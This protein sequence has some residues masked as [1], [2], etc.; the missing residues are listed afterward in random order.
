MSNVANGVEIVIVFLN[1]CVIDHTSKISNIFVSLNRR[2][3]PTPTTVSMASSPSYVHGYVA[4][5]RAR[6]STSQRALYEQI[7]RLH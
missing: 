6:L 2:D 4:S 7:H 1:L 3:N 5:E